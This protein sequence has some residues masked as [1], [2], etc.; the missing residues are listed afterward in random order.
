MTVGWKQGLSYGTCTW[1]MNED[2]LRSSTN[3]E[4]NC[5]ILYLSSKYNALY[6]T[7]YEHRSVTSAGAVV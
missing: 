1:S 5:N 2:S 4:P 7:R 3:V 6:V